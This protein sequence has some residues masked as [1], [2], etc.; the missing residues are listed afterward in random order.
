MK[1]LHT[2]NLPNHNLYIYDVVD[3]DAIERGHI[4]TAAYAN[5]HYCPGVGCSLTPCHFYSLSISCSDTIT[6]F[7]RSNLISTNPEYFI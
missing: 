4:S 7:V 3:T 5:Q 2:F 1:L 6:D